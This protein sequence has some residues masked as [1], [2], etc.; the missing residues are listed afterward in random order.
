MINRFYR[1]KRSILWKILVYRA[2]LSILDSLNPPE[3]SKLIKEWNVKKKRDFR[4]DLRK[5]I[6]TLAMEL[7]SCIWWSRNLTTSLTLYR[8]STKFKKITKTNKNQNFWILKLYLTQKMRRHPCILNHRWA[9][10]MGS[11]YTAAAA[12]TS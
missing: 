8:N 1:V 9:P 6:R 5:K 7:S 11:R 4:E 2:N 12:K 10:A 3:K